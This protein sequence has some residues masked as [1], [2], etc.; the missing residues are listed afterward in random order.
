MSCN[1]KNS[2]PVPLISIPCTSTCRHPSG[3]GQ[4]QTWRPIDMNRRSLIV[5]I[6]SSSL[7]PITA[8]AEKTLPADWPLDKKVGS[9]IIFTGEIKEVI[10]DFPARGTLKPAS[11]IHG[12]A[13]MVVIRPARTIKIPR[14]KLTNEIYV[15]LPSIFPD[16]S[17]LASWKSV[18][19]RYIGRSFIF[20]GDLIS[21]IEPDR[22][23]MIS[24]PN[25]RPEALEKEAEVIA[26]LKT[27]S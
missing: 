12:P 7:L 8:M 13:L 21:A 26:S 2:T 16:G 4:M 1:E 14:G 25:L 23:I 27:K 18:E 24:G 6:A 19:E 15:S 20:F 5:A 3:I 10:W 22:Q 9:P 17:A 11:P